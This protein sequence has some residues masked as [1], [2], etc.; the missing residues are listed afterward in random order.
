[1]THGV[2]KG[3]S[4][5]SSGSGPGRSSEELG[6][7]DPQDGRQLP[8]D[9]QP[10]VGHRPLDPA[11]VDPIDLGVVGQLLLGQLSLM[12]Y[13]LKVGCLALLKTLY[14]LCT[15]SCKGLRW[16]GFIEGGA[17]GN[18]VDPLDHFELV[19][20]SG[21]LDHDKQQRCHRVSRSAG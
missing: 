4:R 5:P 21:E 13:P 18:P 2:G 16:R 3:L 15:V 6:R 10:D 11:H 20:S 8:D 9:L 17:V 1:M 14:G 19:I 12:T 7:L